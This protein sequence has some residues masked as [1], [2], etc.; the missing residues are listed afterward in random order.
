MKK[1]PAART[2]AAFSLIE[3]VL[4][5]GLTSFCLIA[6]LGLLPV[7][8]HSNQDAIQQ[9]EASD[10]LSAAIS[11]LYATPSTTPPGMATNS[12]QFRIPIPANPVTAS[13]VI[14]TLYFVGNGQWSTSLQGGSLYRLTIT[15]L[16]NG[17]SARTATFLDLKVTRPASVAVNNATE[18]LETFVALNRN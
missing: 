12:C 6:L 18:T 3:V 11:D 15:A 14:S 8:L 13:S 7:G 9:A 1:I 17:A 5:L 4:A 2:P 16:T 10:V